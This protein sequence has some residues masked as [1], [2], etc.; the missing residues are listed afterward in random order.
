MLLA[1][2]MDGKPLPREHGAPVRVVIPAMYGYKNTKW[3]ARI[4]VAREPVDGFWEERGYDRD[5][6]VGRSNGY[7]A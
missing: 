6:W 3:V 5:A 4:T 2:E 1:Y 7:G